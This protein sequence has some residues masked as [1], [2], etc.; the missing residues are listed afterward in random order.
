MSEPGNQ[1]RDFRNAWKQI[2][3]K[4]Q[5]YKPLVSKKSGHTRE[6]YSN[7]DLPQEDRNSS[8]KQPHFT[9]KRARKQTTNE[10]SQRKDII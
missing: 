1:S 6:A 4:I 9:P 5:W 3:R 10:T 8:N 7:T 2:K